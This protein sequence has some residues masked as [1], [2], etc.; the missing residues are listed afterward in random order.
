MPGASKL[1]NENVIRNASKTERGVWKVIPLPLACWTLSTG[2]VLA[3][4]TTGTVGNAAAATSLAAIT[5][6]ATADATD[7][8]RTSLVIPADFRA[9]N[10]GKA[11]NL[12]LYVRAR[13]VDAATGENLTLALN[14]QCFWHKTADTALSTL[15][16]AVSNVVGAT[17][18]AAGAEEGFILYKYDLTAAMSSAQLLALSALDTFQIQLLPSA[19]IGTSLTLEVIGTFLVY[20][21]HASIPADVLS[22]LS[23]T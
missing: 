16:A 18:Y 15:S 8:I 7:I 10:S 12:I 20:E 4:T 3:A 9:Q 21:G 13:V 5:W 23:L 1:T 17:D 11:P 22:T 6:N 19:A 14:S 2:V